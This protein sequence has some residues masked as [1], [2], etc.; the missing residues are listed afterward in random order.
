MSIYYHNKLYAR[1]LIRIYLLGRNNQ[2]HIASLTSTGIIELI[3][4]YKAM[5]PASMK[6]HRDNTLKYM[7]ALP[8]WQ[9]VT[10]EIIAFS[11]FL[12]PFKSPGTSR[13]LPF[14]HNH[15][16][17]ALLS[18]S[19]LYNPLLHILSQGILQYHKDHLLYQSHSF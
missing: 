18:L 10:L 14:R 5:F 15:T 2:M 1:G 9:H 3:K 13:T 8:Q 7:R 17:Y 16:T 19:T 4:K 11:Y 6:C 12:S